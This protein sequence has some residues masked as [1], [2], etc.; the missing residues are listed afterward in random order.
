MP[1]A[2]ALVDCLLESGWRF[3]PQAV[4]ALRALVSEGAAPITCPAGT[5]S[6]NQ[7]APAVP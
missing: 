3:C 2:E 1:V 5:R 4:E 6:A 7:P